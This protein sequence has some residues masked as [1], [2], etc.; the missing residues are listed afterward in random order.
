MI[1]ILY[2]YSREESFTEQ[3]MWSDGFYLKGAFVKFKLIF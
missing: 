1:I 3:L 2:L